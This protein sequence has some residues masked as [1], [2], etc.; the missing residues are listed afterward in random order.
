MDC[1]PPG[2]S[3]YEVFQ[4]RIQEW[5]AIPSPGDLPDPG[6]EHMSLTA[7]ALKGVFF[8]TSSIWT[9]ITIF[10]MHAPNG[11][12]SKHVREQHCKSTILLESIL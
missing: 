12:G 1:S 10:T 3:I 7:S 4:A 11:R 9:V 6:S 8:N 5:V 2:S